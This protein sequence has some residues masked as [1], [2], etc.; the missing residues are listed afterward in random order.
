VTVSRIATFGYGVI[1][2]TIAYLITFW[3]NPAIIELT[4]RLSNPF[5]GA[6]LG[7]FL[8]GVFTRRV[9]GIPA[10]VGAIVGMIVVACVIFTTDVSF[11]WYSATSC[12][13]TIL[14]ASLL[15]FL[16]PPPPRE[17]LTDLTVFDR[18]NR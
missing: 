5:T 10:F 6:T 4:Y 12:L 16:F 18:G 14:V 1:I 11:L 8:I 2:L 9:P 17:S 13:T 7:L 3:K 15:T